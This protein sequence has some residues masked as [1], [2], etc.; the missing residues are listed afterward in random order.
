M[1]HYFG[2][3]EQM[4]MGEE[5]YQKILR[6]IA[7]GKMTKLEVLNAEQERMTKELSHKEQLIENTRTERGG[8]TIEQ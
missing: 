6:T 8:V 2:Y 4:E 3:L 5:G 1:I 7:K